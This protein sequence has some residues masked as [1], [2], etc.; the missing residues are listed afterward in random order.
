M[1]EKTYE[2]P[3]VEEYEIILEQ[4]VLQS[5]VGDYPGWDNEQEFI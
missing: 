3:R 4:S 1:K 5:S 2:A